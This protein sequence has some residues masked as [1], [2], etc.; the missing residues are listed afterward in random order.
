MPVPP[1]TATS[2]NVVIL[3]W[4]LGFSLLGLKLLAGFV[5]LARMSAGSKLLL[6]VEWTR[7]AA[8]LSEPFEVRRPVRILQCRGR[9]SMP[10]SWGV[11]HPQIIVSPDA[12]GWSQGRRWIVLAHELA[13]IGRQDWFLQ[14]C[15]E[16]LCC[17]YWFHPLAWIAARKLRHESEQACDDAV[18]NS[19]IPA[20]DY[21]TELLEFARTLAS[22]WRGWATALAI[23]RPSNLERRFTTMLT[24]S[25]NRSRLSR[26]AKLMVAGG[27]LCV[28]LPLAGIRVLAQNPSRESSGPPQGWVLAGSK[29]ANYLTGVD[30]KSPYQGHPTAYLKAGPSATEG[31]GTL[32]Q[33]F[34]AAQ[35]VGKRVRFSAAVKSEGV[36]DWAGLW[37][38]VDSGPVPAV[39]FDNMQDRPIKGTTN[40]QNY[41]VVLDVPKDATG[42]AFGVLLGKSGT[43]WLSNVKIESVG[44]DVPTTGRPMPPLPEGPTNLNFEN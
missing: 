25:V 27:A 31:F 29:P 39:R 10:L 32:M 2:H 28:L 8:E 23:V 9:V 41:H 3:T 38:R 30:P 21:A 11:L 14:M 37:M 6:D 34:S 12:D 19:G 35:Y 1:C 16:L 43:V 4:A 24:T 20:P 13:H 18:L 40:W 5:Q 36:N 44:T 17:A 7:M 42:I 33:S 15:A 26:R 22:S